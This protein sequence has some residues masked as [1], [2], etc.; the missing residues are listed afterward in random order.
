MMSIQGVADH[1]LCV[2]QRIWS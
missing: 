2:V 1:E